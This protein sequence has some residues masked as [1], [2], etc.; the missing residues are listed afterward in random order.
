MEE[1]KKGGME[2]G[3]MEEGTKEHGYEKGW[4]PEIRHP[5]FISILLRIKVPQCE[6]CG[7]LLVLP[8]VIC[9][10]EGIR[11]EG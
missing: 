4:V 5:P 11:W 10:P 1:W 8:F 9:H 7:E 6:V 3:R 2:E